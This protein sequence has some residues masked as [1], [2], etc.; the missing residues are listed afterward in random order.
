MATENRTTKS[1]PKVGIPRALHYYRFYPFW[2]VILE[3]LGANIISSPPTNKKIVQEGV[4]HGYGELCIPLKVYYGHVFHLIENHPELDYLF[5][6][7]YVSE[8][9]EGYFCPK[10]IS[11]PD[12]VKILPGAPEILNF[13]VN[14]KE[15]PITLSAIE[16]GK[17]LGKTRE[18]SLRAYE[19]AKKFYNKYLDF[20]R[21]GA[22]VNYALRLVRREK[23]LKLPK[24]ETEGEITLLLLG[25]EYNLFDTYMNLDFQNKLREMGAEV[26]SLR[27]MP[28]EVF[29]TPV[30]VNRKL[31]NYWSHEEEIMQAIRYFLT[32]GR[33]EIDGVIFL[34]SFACG[35]DS[36]IS[37]LIMRDMK[38]VR[39]PYLSI[40]MDEHTGDAGLKTRIGAFV[41]MIKRKKKLKAK[42]KKE[43][44]QEVEL[45]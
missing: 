3:E 20:L 25:H 43:T 14:V 16:L 24:K 10:F 21:D 11:L 37:E 12:V 15:F 17:Q 31:Q 30:V 38:V 41:E 40:I 4:Q 13:E 35:P 29:E 8:T 44:P 18:Q 5:V 42:Q 33:E 1:K 27:N 22:D 9:K 36:I 32:K 19:K 26:L 23:P 28:K 39:L 45:Y 34:I 2:K 7:R 6:P